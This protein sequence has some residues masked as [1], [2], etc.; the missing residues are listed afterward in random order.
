M[1]KDLSKLAEKIKEVLE[2]NKNKVVETSPLSKSQAEKLRDDY[3]S[4]YKFLGMD[5]INC[6]V[7]EVSSYV[8]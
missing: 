1:V 7:P 6:N 3:L 5:P 2:K 4:D 8:L